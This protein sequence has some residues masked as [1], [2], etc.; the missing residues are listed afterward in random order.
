[1]A[2]RNNYIHSIYLAPSSLMLGGAV[3]GGVEAIILLA[4]KDVGEYDAL[5]WGVCAY[6]LLGCVLG[7][8]L[9]P[10]LMLI[11]RKTPL[12]D[13][14]WSLL[15]SIFWFVGTVFVYKWSLGF[16]ILF[17]IFLHWLVLLLVRRTPLRILT[18]PK[19][20]LTM[21][22]LLI[23]VSAI[24]S[25]TPARTFQYSEP[26][27]VSQGAQMNILIVFIDGLQSED[28]KKVPNL[29]AIA[30]RALFFEN[31]HTPTP[32]SSGAIA[33]F[34]EGRVIHPPVEREMS[35]LAKEM[36]GLGYTTMAVLNHSELSHFSNI[37]R[38]FDHY[39]Y[40]PA[41]LP[42]PLTEGARRL[43]LIKKILEFWVQ[44]QGDSQFHYR[45]AGE[46]FFSFRQLLLKQSSEP[47]FSVV[48]LRELQEPWFWDDKIF[49]MHNSP[50]SQHKKA[51]EEELRKI[52]AAWGRFWGW[53]STLPQSEK[54]I[55]AFVGT[56][57]E[58]HRGQKTF[59]ET[60]LRIPFY[61][62]H[63]AIPGRT[64]PHSVDLVDLSSTM[65]SLVHSE[66]LLNDT[67]LLHRFFWDSEPQP[68][69]FYAQDPDPE[70]GWSMVQ[71]G[72]WKYIE[73]QQAAPELY[74][75]QKDPAEANNLLEEHR[76]KGEQMRG[77]LELRNMENR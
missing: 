19:G 74:N 10:I 44:K 28:L 71:I 20:T 1:M 12:S 52:D 36:N 16:A 62:Y 69:P 22:F 4:G 17:M 11:S 41:K 35:S 54:T 67:E 55:V 53:Y 27:G 13:W 56:R 2:K 6:A 45:S 77:Y 8:V 70:T 39:L 23:V 65:L 18:Q 15:F 25:V 5:F 50:M 33:T 64:I 48:H 32:H 58:L 9:T 46:I 75:I 21:L 7:V 26:K 68:K 31:A 60:A 59:H 76:Q 73:P 38:H 37:Q 61:L 29:G 40:L 63:P 43:E 34:L 42:L 51:Y 30:R 47:W 24:F 3:W 72:Q 49:W 57:G 14:S 66:N